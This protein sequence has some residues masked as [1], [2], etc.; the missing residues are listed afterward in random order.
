MLN[1]RIGEN[2]NRNDVVNVNDL[3]KRLLNIDSRFRTN[4]A[5][6]VGNFQF[7][8]EHTY[9]N[10]IRLKI[11]SVEVPNTFYSFSA[12]RQ[13]ISFNITTKDILGITQSMVVQIEPGN[14]TAVELVA[15]IQNQL[16][17]NFRDTKGIWIDVSLNLNTGKITFL[18]KGVSIVG[19]VAATAAA[20]P[21]VL[22]FTTQFPTTR[23]NGLGM[24]YNLGFRE[25]IVNMDPVPPSGGV[26]WTTYKAVAVAVVDVVMDTY[27]LLGVNDLH[28]V[29]HK[30]DSNYFQV[31]AKII[32]RED[33]NAVIYD[34]GS[35]F[36]S[37]EIVFQQ[38]QNISVLNICLKDT[39]GDLIDLNG[40]NYS[41]TIEITEVLNTRLY[42]FYRNYIWLGTVPQATNSSAGTVGLLNGT[43]PPF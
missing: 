36:V 33:K 5:D 31:L 17:A 23:Y 19:A 12:E 11:S 20:F 13:N 25:I 10:V 7:R 21:T 39:F 29:E 37:N 8:L 41:F 30:T 4:L 2:Y 6:P 22:D 32:I 38:P 40:L 9:K 18:N 16:N 3:R 42:D 28:T 43:G 35:S 34:D 24:G 27:L 15:D 1:T 14:Y 26:L